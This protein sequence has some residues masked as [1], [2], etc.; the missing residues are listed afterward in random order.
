M[1]LI[2]PTEYWLEARLMNTMTQL[3]GIDCIAQYVK[4]CEYDMIERIVEV[5]MRDPVD[6]LISRFF[7]T[8]YKDDSP[9]TFILATLDRRGQITTERHFDNCSIIKHRVKTTTTEMYSLL[10]HNIVLRY[11]HLRVA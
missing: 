2:V 10:H 9:S 3:S 5:S 8:F 4:D 6:G 11:E 1:T 7:N